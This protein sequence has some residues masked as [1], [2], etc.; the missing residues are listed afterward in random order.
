M[1]NGIELAP[2]R[3]VFFWSASNPS[4][5]GVAVIRKTGVV[6]SDEVGQRGLGNGQPRSS[7]CLGTHQQ[8]Q[9]AAS[10]MPHDHGT[11]DVNTGQQCE[12]APSPQHIGEG[13]HP[14]AFLT[15]LPSLELDVPCR[16]AGLG[17]VFS[18]GLHEVQRVFFFPK[19]TV[20]E[21]DARD[22]LIFLKR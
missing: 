20:D 2:H 9:L 8:G 5:N 1:V 17:K 18:D 15:G 12:L 21:H 10:G 13:V 7:L 16:N 14:H 4:S 19:S 6:G 3:F 11:R 22:S